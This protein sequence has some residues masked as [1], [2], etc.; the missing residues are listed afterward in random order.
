GFTY[1]LPMKKIREFADQV[2]TLYVIEE[3]EPF[4][5]EQL[6]AAGIECIGKEKIPRIGELNPDIIAEALLG[7]VRETMHIEEDKKV[8]RPPTLCAGCPH[9]GFYYALS[10]KKNVVVTGDIGCYTLGA[11]E[12]LNSLDSC[13]CMGASISMAHGAQKAFEKHNVEKRV[14][15]VIGDS[16]FFHTGVNSLIDVA[17]N[18]GNT[19]SV[20]LDNRITGMTGH[21]ENPGT[22]FTLMGEPAKEIDIPALVKAIGI[23]H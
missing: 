9:R 14:V 18:K 10:K 4:I 8:G 3:L 17:Y 13:V 16:T 7:E 6:K 1:P 22:G 15:G 21:Q 20:I 11:A 19:V 12:P 5:E 23:E 2:E